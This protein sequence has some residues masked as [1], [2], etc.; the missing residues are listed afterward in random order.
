MSW[1]QYLKSP[2]TALTASTVAML[3]GIIAAV[4]ASNDPV[5]TNLIITSLVS[6]LGGLGG[7]FFQSAVQKTFLDKTS[8]EEQLNNGDLIRAVGRAIFMLF[9]HESKDEFYGD[10]CERLETI[11]NSDESVWEN[12]ILGIEEKEN[13]RFE[14]TDDDLEKL[15]P[16]FLTHYV[17]AENGKFDEIESLSITEWRI[18]VEKLAENHGLILQFKTSLSLAEKLHKQFARY[19][20]KAVVSEF[21]DGGKAFVSFQLRISGEILSNVREINKTNKQIL[22]KIDELI[23]RN[24]QIEA[25]YSSRIFPFDNEFCKQTF[26][27]QKNIQEIAFETLTRV[28]KIGQDVTEIKQDVKKLLENSAEQT[29][30]TKIPQKLP[31]LSFPSRVNFFT[32][33]TKVLESIETSLKEH[34]TAALCGVHGLGKSSIAVEFAY[35]NLKHYSHILFIRAFGA[36]FDRF[37]GEIVGDLRFE[38]DETTTPDQKLE[39]LRHWLAENDNWLL[40]LDNVDDV[41]EINKH[42]FTNLGGEVL[43]TS[44]DELIWQIGNRVEVPN[45]DIKEAAT[46]LYQHWQGIEINEFADIPAEKQ[47]PAMQI[48]DKFGNSPLAMT[49]VG[50][51]LAEESESLDEF[52]ETYKN[53]KTNLL[54]NYNFLSNYQHQE[55]AAPFLL[56]FEAITKPKDDSDDEIPITE[57]LKDYLKIASFLAP[58]DIPEDFLKQCAVKLRPNETDIAENNNLFREA[59]KRLAKSTIFKRNADKQTFSTHRLVQ[60]IMRFEINDEENRLLETISETLKKIVPTFDYTN[61]EQVEPY[62]PHLENFIEYLVN[63][64]KNPADITR[65]DNQTT[66]ILSNKIGRY[67]ECFGQYPT[68]E[69]YYLLCVNICEKIYGDNHQQTAGSYNNLGAVYDS[70]GDYPKAEENHLNALRIHLNILGENHPS[71]AMSYNNLGN[72]YYSQGDYPKAEENHLNAL[73]IHLNIF[74]ENHLDA[75]MSYNN[76]GLVYDAQGDYPKAE[77]NYLNALRIHLNILGENHPSTA[78]SYNNLG[79]VYRSQG[80]YPK[81]E[82]NHLNA[83][84]IRLNILGENHPDTATSYNNLGNVYENQEN[85]EQAGSN[86]EKALSIWK[87]FLPE[88]HPYIQIAKRNLERVRGKL[89]K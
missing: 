13:P 29:K 51:Y 16:D 32:G 71:T 57:I 35:L 59:R 27:L 38:T 80:D 26:N 79:A 34:K 75:A 47:N 77:E 1:T 81:A 72:V 11:A 37:V 82:E 2:K 42:Q 25:L 86:F 62:L 14:L 74:D 7:N 36:E 22:T 68:A 60:E 17:A 70:Q 73:R 41:R 9:L 61:R 33:R 66:N 4:N 53:K 65:A 40:I 85:L 88:Q 48:A 83:L 69:K 3:G 58:D 76:L 63:S 50:Y 56:A 52:L 12:I 21:N 23:E 15:M 20:H 31:V 44:N 46:L 6:A 84:R 43:F 5:S 87:R 24:N 49:F 10:D 54:K 45:M 19:L 30:Q 64:K 28:K 55:V 18:I 67:N 89:G 78:S 8:R 39:M